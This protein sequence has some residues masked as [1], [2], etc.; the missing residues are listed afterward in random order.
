MKPTR[1]LALSLLVLLLAACGGRQEPTLQPTSTP[2]PSAAS[3]TEDDWARIQATGKI[4]V[5]TS[6]D[7]P[8]FE[9]YDANF[10]LQGFDIE[11]MQAIGQE[12]GIAVEF[13]DY[14]FDGLGNALRLGRID[15][16]IAA[17][18]V[19][20]EREE[21]VDFSNIY[22]VSEDAFL[23]NAN[24]DIEQ[25]KK[26]EDVSKLRVG[27]QSG[28][29]YETWVQEN[30]VD[31]GKLPER[32]L[33]VYTAIDS[34]VRDL[35]NDR[36]QVVVLDL[37]TAED[38]ATAETV[39]IVAQGLNRQR[40]AIAIPQEQDSLQ[41]EFNRALATLQNNGTVAALI[42]KYLGIESENIVPVPTPTPEP[43]STATPAGPTATP[44]PVA[45]IDDMSWVA[46]LTY[47]DN[48][49]QNPPVLQP[50]QPFVKTWR[51]RNSGT[52]PWTQSYVLKYVSGNTPAAQMGG[53]PTAVQGQVAPGANYDMSVNLVAPIVPGVYQGFWQMYNAQSVAFGERIY[54]GIRVPAPPTPTPAATATP[55][56][57]IQFTVDRTQIRQGECVVF[58]WNVQNAKAVYFYA[59]GQ[60]WQQNGVAGTGQRT[61]CPPVTTTYELR[62]VRPDNS[63]VVQQ[64][65]INVQPT[66]APQIVRFTVQPEAQVAAGQCVNLQWEV[67]G[68]TTRVTVARNTT[69]LWDGAPVKG[70]LADCP[71]GTGSVSYILTATGPGGTSQ[72]QR[73][74]TVVSVATATPVP[75]PVPE[76][77]VI[78]AFS[79]NPN[80]LQAGQCL[81]VAWNTGGG[82][83]RTRLLKNGAVVLDNGPVSSA[84][85][86]CP[87]TAGQIVYRLEA[88][89]AA[90]QTAS[91][92]QTAS[93]TAA[94]PANPLANTAWSVLEYYN[95][96]GG[97]ASPIAGTN[98]S[99]Q[100]GADGKVSGFSGC[101]N[102]SASYFVEGTAISIS[103]IAGGRAACTEPAGIMEQESAYLNALGQSVHFEIAGTQMALFNASGQKMVQYQ[104]Q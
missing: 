23:A 47:D 25:I 40:F 73:T 92:E 67:Q 93:V 46:D 49:M 56:T 7:Y 104:Q 34:A 77:P 54:V 10:K 9:S 2:T 4:M 29:I 91:Q 14:A 18:S 15:A 50:G 90:G 8:P 63:T 45:C 44:A 94:P 86:D 83:V 12:L 17:I 20:P 57:G 79:V 48:N 28:S 61:E 58:S 5:G 97:M 42:E 60:P 33:L 59:L 66:S 52:C 84:V 13:K 36:I 31:T 19:T 16:A 78:T 88:L 103:N 41:T 39:K 51:I 21:L 65:T 11:L 35:A 72:S 37:P 26:L 71:P 80:Q 70:S 30:L 95:G 22:F 102:Y 89:N 53:Q 43:A 55:V 68:S 76:A 99:I 64:I 87:T 98:L 81:T 101:N 82:T 27:V 32:N 62:V 75:T 6:A 100:F 24:A 96:A 74:I 1:W 38:F 3:S 69:P 85:Q